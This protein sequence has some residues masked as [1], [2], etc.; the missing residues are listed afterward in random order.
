MQ[1]RS[2][3]PRPLTLDERFER[4]TLGSAQRT[5]KVFTMPG[6]SQADRLQARINKE[7]GGK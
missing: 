7:L 2:P 1:K 6:S 3:K 4:L 5:G